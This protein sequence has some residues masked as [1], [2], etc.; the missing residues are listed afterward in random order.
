MAGETQAGSVEQEGEGRQQGGISD[1]ED[2]R[3]AAGEEAGPRIQPQIKRLP[4]QWE[5]VSRL[6]GRPVEAFGGGIQAVVSFGAG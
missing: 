1:G 6:S 5:P 4:W 2:T 3:L